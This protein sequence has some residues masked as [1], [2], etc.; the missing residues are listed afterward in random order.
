MNWF[1][2]LRGSSTRF[3]WD[4]EEC[5]FV[6]ESGNGRPLYVARRL[7]LEKFR[8]GIDSRLEELSAE[9][10][11]DDIRL[12][13]EDL[14]FDVGANIG[15]FAR[16]CENFGA[17]VI[18]FEPDLQEFRALS[19]N[20]SAEGIAER[21]AFWSHS[22]KLPLY[23]ANDTG[24]TSLI[25]AGAHEGEEMIEAWSLD[26]WLDEHSELPEQISLL[27]LEAE[28]A[29]PEIL[30]GCVRN[31]HRFKQIVVDA[32]FERGKS[33]E[34]TLPEVTNLLVANGFQMIRF[35]GSRTVALFTQVAD[36]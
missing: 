13:P 18:C 22:T 28:G 11:L 29:E 23:L 32:G 6:V 1:F 34:S 25:P 33:A 14:V 20:L 26:D 2:I 4:K 12:E 30:L 21:L 7:R 16:I 15:E 17:S 5:L 10:L 19:R 8:S 31:L 27:K 9:Y 24:D 35:G 36:S 3:S